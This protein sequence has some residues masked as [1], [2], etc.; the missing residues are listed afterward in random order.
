MDL[1]L[2]NVLVVRR[3]KSEILVI[4]K[5]DNDVR[6]LGSCCGA[7]P[8]QGGH[9]PDDATCPHSITRCEC[10]DPEARTVCK[11]YHDESRCISRAAFGAKPLFMELVR[12]PQIMD[13]MP[14]GFELRIIMSG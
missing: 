7:R 5:D 12:S 13:N 8:D 1:L 2:Q 11:C 9:G 3:S 6:L 14:H 4:G 10:H